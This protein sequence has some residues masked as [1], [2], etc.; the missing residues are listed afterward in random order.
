LLD[1]FL[2]TWPQTGGESARETMA[3][4]C[5]VVAMHSAEMPAFDAQRD[6][7]LLARNW[8]GFCRHAIR[9]LRD[10]A[11]RAEAGRRAADFA[12]RMADPAPFRAA[13]AEAVAVLLGDARRRASRRRLRGRFDRLFGRRA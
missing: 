7:T 13:T 2:D 9:L 5:P 4:G 3:K 1:L 6:P 11:L 8:D 12:R 10:P